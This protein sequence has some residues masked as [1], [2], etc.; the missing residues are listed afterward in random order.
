MTMTKSKRLG[1][2]W[3]LVNG[4][5]EARWQHQQNL[6]DAKQKMYQHAIESELRE[7]RQQNDSFSQKTGKKKKAV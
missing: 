6:D 1:M 3:E 4:K 5:L 2:V 7:I